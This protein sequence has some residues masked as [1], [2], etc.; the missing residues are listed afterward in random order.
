MRDAGDLAALPPVAAAPTPTPLPTVAPTPTAAAA[1]PDLPDLAAE[2][3]FSRRNRLVLLVA[4]RGTADLEG[5]IYALVDGAEAVRIDV[6]G[7]PLRPGETLEAELPGEYVQRRATVVVELRPAPD[8]QESDIDNN[9]VQAVI[10][11]DVDNDVELLSAELD[12]GDGHL[13]V[14]MRNNSVIPLVGTVTVAVRETA[15]GTL[16]LGRLVGPL[17]IAAGGTQR[18]DFAELIELDLANVQLILS[19]DAINDADSANNVLP[20]P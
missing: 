12:S 7:K 19:T 3:L 17:E 2:A 11:P 20:R 15:P 13:V 14:T 18:F 10:A 6:G 8:V 1:G 16:L 4:N 9:R 5:S